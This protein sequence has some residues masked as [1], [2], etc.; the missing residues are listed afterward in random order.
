METLDLHFIF[1]DVTEWPRRGVIMQDCG[2]WRG[3]LS[4]GRGRRCRLAGLVLMT[5]GVCVGSW[6][7]CS[8]ADDLEEA[9][10]LYCSGKYAECIAAAAA[11][12]EAQTWQES[13]RHLKIRS[14][15]ATGRYAD[16]VATQ[17]AALERFPSSVRLHLLG[18][19]VF[20]LGGQPKQAETMLAE[21][22][23]MAVDS[24]WRYTN[25]TDRIALGRFLLLRGRDAREVLEDCYDR[26]AK[27]RPDYAETYLAIG[28][29]A[30]QKHDYAMAAE[31]FSQAVKFSPDDPAGHL[32]LARS[33]APSE[34]QESDEALARALQLNPNHADSLLM[35][36]DKLIDA[37]HY[38]EA[39][40]VLEKVFQVNAAHP[41]ARA[42]EAV[43]AHLR[44]DVP[45]EEASRQAALEHW[46]A[47]PAVEYLIGRKLSRKYR[48]AEGAACQRRALKFDPNYLPAK[49]QLS[50]DLLRLGEE[51]EG[52]RLVNEVY[53]QDGY[54]VVAHNLVT[55]QETLTEFKT[56]EAD[57]FVLRMDA[58]EADVYGH[59]V[60]DLLRRAKRELCAKYEVE[61]SR[62]VVVEIFPQRKDFAVRTF[63]MPGAVGFLGVC[64]GNVITANSP[65][66][67]G[68]NPSNWQAV[69]WHEFCHVVTLQKTNNKMPRWLSEG[70]SVYEEK[71]KDPSWGQSMTAA[72]RMMVLHGE[73]TPVSRLSGAFLRPPSPQHLQFAYYESALVVEYLVETHGIQT[74]RHILTDLSTGTPIDAV[75]KRRVGSL[76]SLDEQFAQFA[77][78]RAEGL[79]PDADWQPP[80]LPPRA[81]L[82]AIA[83]WSK[84][85]PTNLDGLRLLAANLVEEEEWQEA[86]KP[87]SKLLELHPEDVGP[88]NAYRLLAAI[89]RELGETEAERAVLDKLA[90]LDSDALDVYLRLIELY[91]EI[92]DWEGLV[93]AAERVLAVNPLLPAVHRDLARAAEALGDPGRAIP[94]YRALLRMDPMDPAGAHFR[95]AGL[96]REQGDLKSARRQVL[97]ALEEAPRFRAA[98]RLLLEIVD[99]KEVDRKE[100]GKSTDSDSSE[101]SKPPESELEVE[102]EP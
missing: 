84:Q 37:E 74:V 3:P 101:P 36:A 55:L 97:M 32:G 29:L 48:F 58:R 59:S 30:L 53:E 54:N 8:R 79:A 82:A 99:R 50:Q 24:R 88:D 4:V 102:Q 63:G 93:K 64:F 40:T 76:V 81:E 34:P 22:D 31:A 60:L 19:E 23:T 44:G 6:A 80:V 16:A 13:W 86:K 25:S 73:L 33:Y 65:A 28:E 90:A 87:L 9:Q 35:S 38:E 100:S 69:L 98:H 26:V 96:L 11:A 45:S 95:L 85:H 57:G 52:W 2:A 92:E 61:L 15:L 91:S 21:L 18:R 14:E 70:I 47:N 46:A 39:A 75:L 67:Q 68:A 51:A 20:L 12:I 27:A 43:L 66:S 10:S 72:Y 5:F 94:S 7:R 56:I 71:Q 77:R 89:H 62:P 49:M 1:H 17:E 83:D 41:E 42:Y 78:K